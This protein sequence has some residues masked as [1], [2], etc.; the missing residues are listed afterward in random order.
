LQ[1]IDTVSGDYITAGLDES[2][3]SKS[4]ARK[5]EGIEN[6]LE[7][8]IDKKTTALHLL[9]SFSNR[10]KSSKNINQTANEASL[11]ELK[12]VAEIL[13]SLLEDRPLS[14]GEKLFS[15]SINKEICSR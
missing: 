2:S 7:D 6:H 15:Q 13:N 3:M 8:T 4:E 9:K 12:V 10:L 11:P 5:L 1:H 14:N